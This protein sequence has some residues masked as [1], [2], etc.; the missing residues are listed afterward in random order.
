V[1]IEATMKGE[2]SQI[3]SSGQVVSSRDL[4]FAKPRLVAAWSPGKYDQLRVRVE[5]EIGQL[6]FDDFT[7]QTAGINTGTVFAG[8]PT[9]VPQQDW[10]FEAAWDHRFWGGGDITAT[11]RHYQYQQIVDRVGVVD[12]SGE[13]YDA[14]GD[15]GPGTE[16]D[17]A[18]NLTLPTDKI[19]LANGQLTGA[20][21][22]RRSRAT[23]PTTG[24]PRPITDLHGA[25]WEAHFSQ[26]LPKLKSSWG[27]DIL[28]QFG[29]TE[30]HF[31]EIDVAKVKTYVSLFAE[32]RPRS[33]LTLKVELLN[34][35]ARHV[36]RYRQY[37][38]GPRNNSPLDFS[39]L[40]DQ[41]I[42]RLVRLS[43]VKVF[44]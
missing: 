42:G 36:E 22:F 18:F 44:G 1:S 21:V 19:G 30:Y 14:P 5:R 24:L 20:A 38:D 15:I 34:A 27:F 32:Y 12:P 33:D 37:Y 39:D 40:R 25:D 7:A 28:G 17:A 16:D 26:G 41:R 6:N 9:L 4:Y 31:D 3:A 23:D 2:A 11:V 29:Q 8:N 10:V 35:T 13:V 43:V